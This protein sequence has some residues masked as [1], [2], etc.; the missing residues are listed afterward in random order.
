MSLSKKYVH[1][2]AL[3]W[4]KKTLQIWMK[5]KSEVQ[6]TNVLVNVSIAREEELAKEPWRNDT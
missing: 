1:N 6:Q 2:L 4:G 5:D 3:G